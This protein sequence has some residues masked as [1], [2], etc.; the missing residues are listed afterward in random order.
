MLVNGFGF[1]VKLHDFERV[2]QQLQVQSFI[3]LQN[4][5]LSLGFCDC[6]ALSVESPPF[7]YLCAER[8]RE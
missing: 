7:V 2:L 3:D 8:D 6:L 5:L 4:G 1:I